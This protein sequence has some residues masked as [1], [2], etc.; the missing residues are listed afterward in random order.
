MERRSNITIGLITAIIVA[1]GLIVIFFAFALTVAGITLTVFIVILLFAAIFISRQRS[2][3]NKFG[4]SFNRVNFN[5][6]K[7][8]I[9]LGDDKESPLIK[10]KVGYSFYP[11]ES[12]KF[13]AYSKIRFF[14]EDD[15]Y[16]VVRAKWRE[17]IST[18]VNLRTKDSFYPE[19]ESEI[20]IPSLN[21]VYQIFSSEPETWRTVFEDRALSTRLTLLRSKLSYILIHKE[22]MEVV[23][24]NENDFE[25]ILELIAQIAG[26]VKKPEASYETLDIEELQCYSCGDPFDSLEQECTKCE[27]PRPRCTVCLLDLR[28]SEKDLVVELPCCG[29]YAHKDH[30]ISWLS[31]NPKCPNCTTDLESFLTLVDATIIAFHEKDE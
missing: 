29:V 3:I 15:I 6:K 11:I 14:V 17:S 31:E 13:A 10:E 9:L 20:D 18:I 8:T 27:A 30:I 16:L 26:I 25:T 24:F 5:L 7:I 1:V 2:S 19:F 4:A 22:D 12:H 28:P 21:H 23:I